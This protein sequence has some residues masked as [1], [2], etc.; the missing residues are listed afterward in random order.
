MRVT[1]RQAAVGA[2][3]GAALLSVLAAYAPV[4]S[5]PPVAEDLQWALRGATVLR[6]PAALA[7]TFH[8]HLRPAGDLFFAGCAAA[9]DGRWGGYRAAQ[10]GFA[11]L[12]AAAGWA[13][14]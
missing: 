2:A 3:V 13:L 12:L 4:V 6:M 10:L 14:A 11:A 7:H 8:Q 1:L 9:F 5:L